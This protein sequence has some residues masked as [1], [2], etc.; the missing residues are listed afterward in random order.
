MATGHVE[1]LRS[2]RFRAVVYAGHDPITGRKRSLEESRADEFA[3]W[4]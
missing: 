3:H 1:R 4:R 2:G